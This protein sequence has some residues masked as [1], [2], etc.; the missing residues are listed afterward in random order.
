MLVKPVADCAGRWVAIHYRLEGRTSVVFEI[1]PHDPLQR[2]IID[3][4]VSFATYLG[5]SSGDTPMFIR[6][7]SDGSVII[8]GNTSSSDAPQAVELTGTSM[9]PPSV[10]PPNSGLRNC[11][12]EKLAPGATKI[13]FVS[14]FGGQA[15][16]LCH[17][18]D[19]DQNG[20]ILIDGVAFS[21]GGP[22]VTSNAQY[23]TPPQ[24]SNPN[25]EPYFLARISADGQQLDYS[26]YLNIG[27]NPGPDVVALA[28][29]NGDQVYLAFGCGQTP[30]DQLPPISGGYQSS[31]SAGVLRYDIGLRTAD[32]MTLFDGL[33]DG[34][35]GLA[36]SPLGVVYAYGDVLDQSSA[37]QS[38]S[39]PRSASVWRR[40][41]VRRCLL[42]RFAFPCVQH[43]PRRAGR[44]H[45]PVV[46]AVQC[47][48]HS[49]R[50]RERSRRSDSRAPGCPVSSAKHGSAIQCR[51]RGGGP[52]VSPGLLWRGKQ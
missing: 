50:F 13:D 52:G 1:G 5:G 10:F 9:E 35:S 18:A 19:V 39:K 38:Y 41:R 51:I 45:V 46:T 17:S 48:Q 47:R 6:E 29:G 25:L 14:Y 42:G 27:D 37:A 16:V 49:A 34:I 28:A 12:I 30:C 20:R 4:V 33:G 31:G 8:V 26:T 24:F 21:L 11:F 3:P 44:I 22:I 32:Q 36:I 43:I 23:P 2:L 40:R 15:Q 7:F